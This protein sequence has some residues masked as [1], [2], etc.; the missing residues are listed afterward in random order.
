MM[1]DYRSQ[2]GNGLKGGEEQREG[3]DALSWVDDT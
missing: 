1:Y 2:S 3:L